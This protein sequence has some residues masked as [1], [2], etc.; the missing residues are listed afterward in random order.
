M[1]GVKEDLLDAQAKSLEIA[2]KKMFLLEN[3]SMEVYDEL[4]NKTLNGL[5]Q[6]AF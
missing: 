2:L 3:V 6:E 5:K 1:H 4:Y